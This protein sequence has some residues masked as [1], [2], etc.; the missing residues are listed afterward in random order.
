MQISVLTT[1]LS[2][3]SI[4]IIIPGPAS[5]VDF[6]QRFSCQQGKQ[7]ARK[8]QRHS[9]Y[10][11]RP[12]TDLLTKQPRFRTSIN[13]RLRRRQPPAQPTG[14]PGMPCR[15]S[16]QRWCTSYCCTSHLR[17]QQTE[18]TIGS[19]TATSRHTGPLLNKRPMQAIRLLQTAGSGLLGRLEVRVAA[20]DGATQTVPRRRCKKKRRFF[21]CGQASPRKPGHKRKP[22][23]TADLRSAICLHISRFVLPRTCRSFRL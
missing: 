21:V 6:R 16:K 7:S 1:T 13:G 10:Q 3:D 4:A 23:F 18:N 22:A 9:K 11:H 15:L 8:N 14:M 2:K 20:P 5:V 12:H 17:S 19:S